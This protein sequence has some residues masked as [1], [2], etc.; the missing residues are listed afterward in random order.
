LGTLPL[1]RIDLLKKISGKF[2]IF[3]LSNT[4]NIHLQC[5][6][7]IAEDTLGSSSWDDLFEKAYYSHLIKMRK[8]DVAIYRYVLNENNLQAAETLFLDDNLSNLHGA[9]S[10][11]I[12]TF[13]VTHPD[14]IFSLFHEIQS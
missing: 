12:Q 13:H 6:T 3:L 7:E 9:A 2:R 8:P 1:A 5:F 4:N 11:G 14:L 10:I